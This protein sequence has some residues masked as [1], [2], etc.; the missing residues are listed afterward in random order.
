MTL[1]TDSC[2]K[3]RKIVYEIST[4]NQNESLLDYVC[5]IKQEWEKAWGLGEVFVYYIAAGQKEDGRRWMKFSLEYETR[6]VV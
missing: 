1:Q 4:D 3:Y 5:S 2:V 6:K